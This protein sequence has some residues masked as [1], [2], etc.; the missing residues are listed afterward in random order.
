MPKIRR[1]LKK[2]PE[3]YIISKSKLK[4]IFA[5]LRAN[6]YFNLVITKTIFSSN[7]NA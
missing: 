2:N 1:D 5:R 3:K 7:E 6:I 4:Y